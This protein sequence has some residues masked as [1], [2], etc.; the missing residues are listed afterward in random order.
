MLIVNNTAPNYQECL[1]ICKP[2]WKHEVIQY[3]FDGNT[4]NEH[5]TNKIQATLDAIRKHKGENLVYLDTDVFQVK[6]LK[7]EL[8]TH[9]IIATRMVIRQERPYYKEVNAGVFLIKANDKTEKFCEKWLELD[10]E[11]QKDPEIPYPEQRAFNDLLYKYYDS[12]SGITVG[13][14][15]E[16]LYN[17]ERDDTKEWM[18]GIEKYNPYLIHL[19]SK[20]WSKDFS[21]DW[22]KTYVNGIIK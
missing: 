8:F 15:S 11:Y 16:N 5:C 12:D 9:D 14:I 6:P 19:K 1:D 22:L 17:F 7:E 3:N 10:K 20:R 4:F 13:N 21:M 2:S 18:T